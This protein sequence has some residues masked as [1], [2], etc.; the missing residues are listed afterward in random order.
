[1]YYYYHYL[2][3]NE[4]SIAIFNFC[5]GM[6][7]EKKKQFY[8]VCKFFV[9]STKLQSNFESISVTMYCIRKIIF[10]CRILFHVVASRLEI[11]IFV[12]FDSLQCAVQQHEYANFIIR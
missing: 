2:V 1:M 7:H 4:M 3:L 9:A 11:A 12:D 5:P 8:A 6:K 10:L